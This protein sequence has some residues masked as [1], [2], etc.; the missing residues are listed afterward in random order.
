MISLPQTVVV[1]SPEPHQ[2]LQ[3]LPGPSLHDEPVRGLGYCEDVEEPQQWQDGEHQAGVAPV[4]A[5]VG[6]DDGKAEAEG[7]QNPP[8]T[9]N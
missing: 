8:S 3:S 5:Q 9:V 2:S 7:D 1:G 6:G 4:E